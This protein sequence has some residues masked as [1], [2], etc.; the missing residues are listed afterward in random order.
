MTLKPV[1][2]CAPY[3]FEGQSGPPGPPKSTKSKSIFTFV[4]NQTN[5]SSGL[6]FI[7]PSGAGD[8]VL[9]H[10]RM[11]EYEMKLAEAI[12]QKDIP[13]PL[14]GRR[15]VLGHAILLP[16]PG[17]GFRDLF[18][19]GFRC[20]PSA[21]GPK[22]GPRLPGSPARAVW[23]RFVVRLHQACGPNRPKTGP[24]SQ[25]RGPEAQMRNLTC[26]GI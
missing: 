8:P 25:V 23:D 2:H 14:F 24:G 22:T 26:I 15:F 7:L 4:T 12:H 20:K 5:D 17:P 9:G 18:W 11:R 6:L 3:R 19:T 21:N 13:W 10:Y 16:V 1:G